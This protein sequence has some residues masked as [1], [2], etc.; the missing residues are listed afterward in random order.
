[1]APPRKRQLSTTR[2]SDIDRKRRRILD[3]VRSENNDESDS[4]GANISL[5]DENARRQFADRILRRGRRRRRPARYRS[6]TSSD[7]SDTENNS[8]PAAPQLNQQNEQDRVRLRQQ[9]IDEGVIGN[10]EVD[11]HRFLIEST[12]NR[13]WTNFNAIRRMFSVR[14]L[15]ESR[16]AAQQDM[17][18]RNIRTLRA[19]QIVILRAVDIVRERHLEK[20]RSR[21]AQM[22]LNLRVGGLSYPVMTG[23]APLFRDEAI[24]ELYGRLE[25][26][27][28]SHR[29]LS[30]ADGL[31][32]DIIIIDDPLNAQRLLRV[33]GNGGRKFKTF[34]DEHLWTFR[35]LAYW[36]MTGLFERKN[37]VPMPFFT[38]DACPQYKDVCLFS[39]IVVGMLHNQEQKK[40]LEL[41]KL[42]DPVTDKV[43]KYSASSSYVNIR[44]YLK[45]S[46]YVKQPEAGE[47]LRKM[48]ADIVRRSKNTIQ[49]LRDEMDKIREE[50]DIDIN[51]FKSANLKSPALAEEIEKLQI[52]LIVYQDVLHFQPVMKY[53]AITDLCRQ[54][55][56]VILLSTDDETQL[57]HA[58]VLLSQGMQATRFGDMS[59]YCNL[60]LK[61]FSRS[62]VH[63]HRCFSGHQRCNVCR[64][65]KFFPEAYVDFGNVH[66]FCGDDPEF[67]EKECVRCKRIIKSAMCEKY[68]QYLC[69][70]ATKKC[71]KC[72]QV[73]REIENRPHECGTR[74]CLYCTQYV[75]D[76]ETDENYGGHYCELRRPVPPQYFNKV[77]FFD[78]ESM[79]RRPKLD[80]AERR[81]RAQMEYVR[82]ARKRRRKRKRGR[83][84]TSSS[85][86]GYVRDSRSMSEE[87]E[88][89]GITTLHQ[90]NAVCL[91]YEQDGAVGK[92]NDATFF[93]NALGLEDE[94]IEN[95]YEYDYRCESLRKE[96]LS[97]WQ[98][99]VTKTSEKQKFFTSNE[100][101]PEE[102][103]ENRE[104]IAA[105]D[106][107]GGDDVVDLGEGQVNVSDFFLSEAVEQRPGRNETEEEEEEEEGD[108]EEGESEDEKERVEWKK[109]PPYFEW[110]DRGLGT[111]EELPE[112]PSKPDKAIAKF[113]DFI[114]VEKKFYSMSL[115]SH[116]GSFF[117]HLLLLKE[118]TLRGLFVDVL[119]EGNRALVMKI[120]SRK[121]IFVDS[122]RYAKIPLSAFP[123][124]FSELNDEEIKKGDHFPYAMNRPMYYDYA[125]V[126]PPR[127]LFINDYDTSYA[128]EAEH[129]RFRSEWDPE[130]QFVFKEE[131]KKY[132]KMDVHVLRNGMCVLLKEMFQYQETLQAKYQDQVKINAARYKE[133]HNQDM[134]SPWW[135]PISEDHFTL[136]S[137]CHSL[138]LFFAMPDNCFYNTPDQRG[139]RKT[140]TKELQW[141][142]YL[143]Y[144]NKNEQ[145]RTEYS[146]PEGQKRVLDGLYPDGYMEYSTIEDH[147]QNGQ[148]IQVKVKK[149]RVYEFAGCIVHYHAYTNNNC[150][151]T[152]HISPQD[153]N[154]FGIRY[155]KAALRFKAKLEKYYAAG[156]EVVVMTECEFD[157]MLKT[158][159]QLKTFLDTWERP[160]SRMNVRSCLRGGRVETFRLLYEEKEEEELGQAKESMQYWDINSL[161]PYIATS[162][163][164]P[165]GKSSVM[166]GQQLNDVTATS[167][168]FWCESEK[169]YLHG[170]AQI[171][172]LPP[173][174]MFIPVLAVV[175]NSKLI[176]GLCSKCI[177]GEKQEL[178]LHSDEERA[179]TCTYTTAEITTAVTYGYKV[180]KIHEM[181]VYEKYS[182]VLAPYYISLA[183]AKI[184]AEKLPPG[185]DSQEDKEKYVSELTSAMPGLNLKASEL[186]YN[187]DVRQSA[188]LLA[189]LSLGKSES[190]FKA[191]TEFFCVFGLRMCVRMYVRTCLR[192]YVRACAE[193]VT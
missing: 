4:D 174:S 12:L 76:N 28:V 187:S 3:V 145:I 42:R 26:V 7:N 101:Y 66:H 29:G 85:S 167:E 149:I 163:S 114:L 89:D 40:K 140:S 36:R 141:L 80:D 6:S 9:Q 183:K 75:K 113:V 137:H 55:V 135:H 179:L 19:V 45:N 136:G 65:L 107:L 157:H 158:D 147:F 102:N 52:N 134:R 132:L 144:K 176:F 33:A 24:S 169:K 61:K 180:K 13:R 46:I 87:G 32:L 47:R 171:T 35:R 67:G 175:S 103:E 62:K 166:I 68:H 43:C 27:L 184:A 100:F 178:C 108:D 112:R 23:L 22:T 83:R 130:K 117:D 150:P 8:A 110:C 77:A 84:N 78:F 124:R 92:F 37:I 48:E 72:D 161:Y 111:D 185:I 86:S 138:W 190:T 104:E 186:K 70:R 152:R 15:G 88:E 192:T 181:I 2:E 168:G 16:D 172:I 164:L 126:L 11:G 155:A 60:C 148:R 129:E 34:R 95:S 64:R 165:H 182:P 154:P 82:R 93:D 20:K 10:F 123:R 21:D 97:R 121:L 118:F 53:P 51:V 173:D 49:I 170:L 109:Y 59:L 71:S 69:D 25:Q 58:A 139:G 189:N 131:L 98:R 162:F 74:Y 96:G 73:Y 39:A 156:Y 56:K 146:H 125:D 151:I 1:M 142:A 153:L 159:K 128:K 119:W 5:P 31:S 106:L 91:S 160:E 50:C 17:M 30:L 177:A 79:A 115:C 188:K 105:V 133:T 44:R 90:V 120:P 94:H 14:Y 54:T 116:N 18:I 122:L 143:N 81:K 127:E 193:L 191:K 41:D 57:Y 63:Q 99:P 38:H